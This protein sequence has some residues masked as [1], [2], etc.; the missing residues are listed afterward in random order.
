VPCAG[1]HLEPP[2]ERLLGEL[3]RLVDGHDL[4][5]VAHAHEQRPS[6]RRRDAGE[7]EAVAHRLLRDSE[8]LEV[9]VIVGER[10]SLPRTKLGDR[11]LPEA[12]PLERVRVRP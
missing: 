7:V 4:V 8:V 1:K 6:E 9:G 5:P 2:I 12:A 11:V 10:W 3:T